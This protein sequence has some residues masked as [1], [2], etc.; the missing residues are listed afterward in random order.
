MLLPAWLPAQNKLPIT[1]ASADSLRDV[2]DPKISPDGKW[3]SYSVSS[4]NIEK[5]YYQS[6]VWMTSW[7]GAATLQLTHTTEEDESHARWSPDSRYLSFLSSR[8]F[9]KKEDDEEATKQLWLLN[10]LGGEAEQITHFYGGVEDYAWSPD[11]KKIALIVNVSDTAKYMEGTETVRPVVIDRFYFKE[12]YSGYLTTERKHLYVMDVATGD[13]FRVVD[14]DYEEELPAWSP[15]GKQIAFVSKRMHEDWDRDDNYDVWVVEAKP[16]AT[17]KQISKS[18]GADCDP[19][20]ESAP[21]WSPDGKW[22]AYFQGGPLKLIYYGTQH[23][24]IAPANGG[25]ATVLTANYDRNIWNQKFSADGKEIYF[26]AEDDQNLDL[27]KISVNGGD[28]QQVLPGRY[29]V[30]S[31]DVQ[32]EKLAIQFTDPNQPGEIY[33]VEG[34]TKRQLSH[35]NDQW[36]AK[37][38]IATT[39]EFQSKSK[40]G[41]MISG[42]YVLPHDYAEGKKYPMILQIH[43]GPTSQNQNEWATDWQ[44][45]AAWGYVTV[46]MNPRGSTT[47]GEKFATAL[48]AHWGDIDITDDLSGVDELVKRGIADP[49]RLAV[50]GWSY[51]GIAT[52]YMIAK[53]QRFKCAISGASIGNAFAGFGTDMYIREYIEE[54]GTPWRDFQ[55][56]VNNSYPFLHADKIKTPT[57][58]MCGSKDFNVPL[59]NSEQMYQALKVNNVETQLIIYPDQFH[60][61]D[62]PG[63]IRDRYERR[64]DWFDEHLK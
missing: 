19:S 6:D 43:G 62:I 27:R 36:L 10:R 5:D 29:T 8:K 26:V 42:F 33:A 41:T 7:D 63:Y 47:K 57:L 2:S 25:D 49:N 22:I 30:Y 28:V 35:Q 45:Y 38:A 23:L 48:F 18:E 54:L 4:T 15:D 24:A 37:H 16:H 50:E 46:S 39:K 34:N 40:D 21:S 12:D 60:G 55:N 17:P 32:Q 20:Y 61:L 31:F 51:G 64:K 9:E 14:G 3:V 56:Y 1:I 52:D 11:G 58:F 44:L 53:D 13:T 59:L